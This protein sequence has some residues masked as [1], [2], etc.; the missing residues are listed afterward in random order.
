MLIRDLQPA[1][2]DIRQLKR[3]F[4][5]ELTPNQKIMVE[6]ELRRLTG[7]PAAGASPAQILDF[8]CS[9]GSNW[10]VLHNLKLEGEEGI[11]RIDH[12]LINRFYE[13][14]LLNTT[15]FY[16]DLKISVDGEYKL[17]DGR[18]YHAIN[19]PEQICRRQLGLLSSVFNDQI[20]A[21]ARLGVP[22]RPKFDA[23]I[24]LSPS[25][26]VIR[27]PA[28]VLDTSHVIAVDRFIHRLLRRRVRPR[29]GF[30]RLGLLARY[31]SRQTLERIARELAALHQRACVDFTA[32]IG[33][34]RQACLQASGNSSVGAQPGPYGN[35]AANRPKPSAASARPLAGGCGGIG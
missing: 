33:L 15:C 29:R 18:E 19:S 6:S 13:V 27:P 14:V 16:H 9:H 25:S 22:L 10:A 35:S 26:H 8:Y 4:D 7:R 28:S 23:V 20:L 21:P 17:F 32:A 34:D 12:L 1:Q 30:S 3:L 2:E 31:C 24:L 5:R 11:E